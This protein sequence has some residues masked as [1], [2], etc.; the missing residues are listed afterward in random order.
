MEGGPP[1]FNP[2][3]TSPS[4]L[5]GYDATF[6]Y[7]TF[8]VFG[9]AFQR[10][11][12]AHIYPLSLAATYGVACCF[13]FLQ[14]LRCFSSLGSPHAPMHSVRDTP[15]GGLPHSDIYRS[16]L[17]YQLPVAFRRFQRLSSPLDAKSSTV[18]PYWLDHTDLMPTEIE[19]QTN[20]PMTSL[21]CRLGRPTRSASP[22]KGDELRAPFRRIRDFSV[23][24]CRTQPRARRSMPGPPLGPSDLS[25]ARRH[26]LVREA[27]LPGSSPFRSVLP[28]LRGGGMIGRTN[29][30]SNCFRNNSAPSLTIL[31]VDLQGVRRGAPAH[32][33]SPTAQAPRATKNPAKRG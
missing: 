9:H 3:S 13:P 21:T 1:M 16:Q 30:P 26:P 24:I 20:M 23:S 12:R 14:V 17:G 2:G 11:H 33:D 7:R 31:Y 4:L 8:T 28:P 29:R 19:H 18:C 25:S 27:D 10:V 6:C 15:K 5:E 22:G 32:P